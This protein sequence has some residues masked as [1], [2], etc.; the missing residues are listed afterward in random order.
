M[1]SG[2]RDWSEFNYGAI[3]SLVVNQG[4]FKQPSSEV[5]AVIRVQY[6]W[7]CLKAFADHVEVDLG[8]KFCTTHAEL[9]KFFAFATLQK[10]DHAVTMN[11]PV[12]QSLS[13]V[14]S[15]PKTWAPV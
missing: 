3:S 10:E 7:S 12:R 1:A 15:L 4:E 13:S 9:S 5:S 6:R 11:R 8:F 2:K 14:E